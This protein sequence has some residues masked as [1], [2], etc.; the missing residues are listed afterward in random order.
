MEEEKP[1]I[2]NIE[3][4]REIVSLQNINNEQGK[5][6]DKFMVIS[7]KE[8]FDIVDALKIVAPGTSLR[9]GIDDIVKGQRGAL[10][11]I[12]SGDIYDVISGGFKI[13]CKF[14][15]QK[16]FE[17][18]KMD[19]ALILS[20]DLKKI[21]YANCLLI[22]NPEI[23]SD[24]TGT[25]HQAAERT[26][27]QTKTLTISISERKYSIT[28]YYN[29]MKYSLKDTRDILNKSVE[30]LQ[31]LEKQKEIYSNLIS[32]LNKL[33]VADLVSI[34]DVSSIFQRM[35]ILFRTSEMM[36]RDIIE[37]GTEGTLL[38]MRMKELIKGV[39]KNKRLMIRDYCNGN[40]SRFQKEVAKLS[41]DNL[42]ETQKISEIIFKDVKEE[43]IKPRG[44]RLLDK[45]DFPVED[46][47]IIIEHFPDINKIFETNIG[48]FE[49]IL[50]SSNKS[51]KFLEE[52]SN[53]RE[54]IMME[55]NL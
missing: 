3:I 42:L 21:L 12:A 40:N 52:L 28:L 54:N 16:L 38:K 5:N 18:S 47:E 33:E 22:P 49:K 51:E 1:N 30:K 46:V 23:P 11:V 14:T 55:K 19:G 29:D 50:K 31:F 53:L 37:L 24:E 34:N 6:S 26:A 7:K 39:D 13:N 2:P 45:I 48:E 10:I 35:E 8:K 44:Y 4:N 43:H 9:S 20:S 41:F 15:P 36:K 25:R 32:N 27:K 17:L